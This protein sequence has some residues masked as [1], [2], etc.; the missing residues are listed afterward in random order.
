MATATK[1]CWRTRITQ[2]IDADKREL[3]RRETEVDKARK[4]LAERQAKLDALNEAT[5]AAIADV[6]AGG[7]NGYGVMDSR[8]V[9][10]DDIGMPLEELR[11]HVS[12]ELRKGLLR[13]YVEVLNNVYAVCDWEREPTEAFTLLRLVDEANWDGLSREYKKGDPFKGYSGL[14]V[15]GPDGKRRVLCETATLVV[16]ARGEAV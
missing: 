7:T 6:L 9:T 15:S 14:I 12:P 3:I 1:T 4:A 16:R 13:D 10:P 2:I 5:R 11:E 8:E